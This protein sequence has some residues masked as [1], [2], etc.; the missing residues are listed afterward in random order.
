MLFKYFS[1]LISNFWKAPQEPVS[2]EPTPSHAHIKPSQ[3]IEL[4]PSLLLAVP[5]Y[6]TNEGSC[7]A[8]QPMIWRLVPDPHMLLSFTPPFGKYTVPDHDV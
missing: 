4:Y 8:Q 2:H 3:V 5:D 1:I 7:I 6:G